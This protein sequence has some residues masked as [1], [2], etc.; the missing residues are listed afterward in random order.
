[1][2]LAQSLEF[3]VWIYNPGLGLLGLGPSLLGFGS[4]LQFGFGFTI[5]GFGPLD[6]V[7][8][9]N[10]GSRASW[11]GCTYDNEFLELSADCALLSAPGIELRH[12][13]GLSRNVERFR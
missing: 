9:C 7:R 6:L 10:P 5:Q 12:M 13:P 8:V 2:N 3:R 1:M 4:G 11:F